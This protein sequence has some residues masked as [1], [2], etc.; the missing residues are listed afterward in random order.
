MSTLLPLLLG[1]QSPRRAA[2]LSFFSIPFIQ[3]PSQ[4]DEN[5][6][7]WNG[8]PQKY[9]AAISQGKAADLQ[10][11]NPSAL[12][13]TADT[14]V[15]QE[16]KLFLKPADREDAFRILSTLAGK[17]H[18]VFTAVTLRHKEVEFTEVE[19]TRVLFNPLTQKQIEHYLQHLPYADKAGSYFIQDEGSLLAKRID[20]CFYN[21]MGLPINTVRS[22]LLH[23]GIDLWDYLI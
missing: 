2:I 22:L 8:D 16:G 4:F 23:F 10:K 7:L 19:E 18:S 11:N 21:V 5:S 3:A 13:L 15:Y 1:S 14:I 12:L 9:A 20:G 6:I 17:W